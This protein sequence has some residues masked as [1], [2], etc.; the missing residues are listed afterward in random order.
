MQRQ[1]DIFD[2]MEKPKTLFEQIFSKVQ[3]PVVE[4]TNCLCQYCT[5]NAEEIH[6]AVKWAEAAEP[7]CFNCD[8]CY[9]Y[10]EDTINKSQAK[11]DCVGA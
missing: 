7:T 11:E 1:M 8:E 2:Y 6:H 4:C 3:N 10:T 9:T 5:H